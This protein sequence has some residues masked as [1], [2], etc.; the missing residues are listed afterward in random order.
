MN[1]QI[2]HMYIFRSRMH[3]T[4]TTQ[5]L[6]LTQSSCLPSWRWGLI[7]LQLILRLQVGQTGSLRR[8]MFVVSSTSCT[9][10]AAVLLT[11]ARKKQQVNT[12]TCSKITEPTG[13]C[14]MAVKLTL[15]F[16]HWSTQVSACFY[17]SSLQT[18]LMVTPTAKRD[19]HYKDIW[20]WNVFT[21]NAG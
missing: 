6:L 11:E 7:N 19:H 13:T 3:N 17:L 14:E 10:T 21:E 1:E 12:S 15:E 18:P 16:F 4:L 9:I 2:K 5:L 8:K 20:K